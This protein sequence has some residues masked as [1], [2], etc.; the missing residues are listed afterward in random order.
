MKNLKIAK[1]FT[2]LILMG[3]IALTGCSFKL[4]R[5][6]DKH[7]HIYSNGDDFFYSQEEYVEDYD[8]KDEYVVAN[9]ENSVL[10][11]T[12]RYPCSAVID[13]I[14]EKVNNLNG[15]YVEA[16]YVETFKNKE[17]KIDFNT[18]WRFLS[19]E[20]LEKHIGIIRYGDTIKYIVYDINGNRF[21]VDNL[22]DLDGEYFIDKDEFICIDNP[23][24]ASCV[25]K[26]VN[27]NN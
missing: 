21:E 16:A 25:R 10:L 15:K 14:E 19:N 7:Y 23:V 12:N 20:E 26:M 11:E 13:E 18:Y 22:R 5:E 4:C 6:K 24:E 17:G 3:T 8:K 27:T 2:A 1:A 9:E